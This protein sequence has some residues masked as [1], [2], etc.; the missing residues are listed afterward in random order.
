MVKNHNIKLWKLNY[1]IYRK[2]FILRKYTHIINNKI[3]YYN[4]YD[5]YYNP[6]SFIR[7]IVY[8]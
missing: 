2:H 7:T 8:I 5:G 3:I 6:P 1:R 4:Y